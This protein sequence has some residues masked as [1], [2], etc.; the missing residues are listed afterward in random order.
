[1]DIE[2]PRNPIFYLSAHLWNR[3]IRNG[4]SSV[5]GAHTVYNMR[6]AGMRQEEDCNCQQSGIFDERQGRNIW[7]EIGVQVSEQWKV[8]DQIHIISSDFEI[9]L[10]QKERSLGVKK[11]IQECLW[12]TYCYICEWLEHVQRKTKNLDRTQLLTIGFYQERLERS[13]WLAKLA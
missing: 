1:M 8:L 10:S 13:I 4:Y 9:I 12:G 7:Y 5:S 6:V 11:Q 2:P 3:K